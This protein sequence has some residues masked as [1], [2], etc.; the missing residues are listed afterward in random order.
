MAVVAATGMG[1]PVS[2]AVMSSV[3]VIGLVVQLTDSVSVRIKG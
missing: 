2:A 1:R 3:I